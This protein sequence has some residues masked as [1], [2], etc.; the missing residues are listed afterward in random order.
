M[1]FNVG[2]YIRLSQEDK[3]KKYESDSESVI[4]QRELLRSYVKNNGFILVDEYV[5]DGYSGT[6]FDRPGFQ[7]LLEDIKAKKINCVIV[8]DLSRLGRDHVMTG[9]YIETFFPENNIRFISILESFD[10]FKNQASNDS[11]T[12]IIACNDYYSKQNSIKI[13]NV[14]N[15]KRKNGKFIGSYPSFGYMRDEFD[16][17]HLVINPETAPIVKEIFE[18]RANGVGPSEITTILNNKKYPTPSKYKKTKFSSR[19][20]RND[21][22]NISSVS[23]I[24]KNRIYTGDMVQHTQTKVSYKSKKKVTLDKSLWVIVENTHEPIIDKATFAYIQKISKEKTRQKNP[25]KREKRLLEGKL[26]CKECGNSISVMYRRNHDY[27][28]VNC[29]KYSRDPK[30]RLCEPH[31]FPYEYLEKQVL[32]EF[33]KAISKYIK[34][35]DIKEINNEVL[36]NTKKN[37]ININSKLKDME[38]EKETTLNKIKSL[39][40]DKFNNIISN[41]IY[42]ELSNPLEIKL[43]EINNSIEELKLELEGLKCEKKTIPD[44]TEKIKKLLDLDKPKKE[45]IETLLDKIIIDNDKNIT[46]KFKRDVISDYTF[47]YKEVNAIRNPYGRK[48]KFKNF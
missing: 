33:K 19:Q 18:L 6:D 1:D 2:I 29:N 39:Y 21:I 14:L 40:D 3:D 32:S 41:D 15:D 22:W 35:L 48:G 43:K 11:S 34:E 12:F 23:K 5:D 47:K 9:Y 16:K 30:R 44:Y 20:I 36:K 25:T 10:S 37:T 27:W 7:R 31:F 46:F 8:K 26:I 28:S 38:K 13:R 17:G 45:L 24:L 42:K 4:N